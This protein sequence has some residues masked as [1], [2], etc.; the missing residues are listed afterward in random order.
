MTITVITLY[1][2]CIETFHPLS[3]FFSTQYTGIAHY[4]CLNKAF[5]V[6]IL[7]PVNRTE[8]QEAVITVAATEQKKEFAR[9]SCLGCS[10]SAVFCFPLYCCVCHVNSFQS[11]DCLFFVCFLFIYLLKIDRGFVTDEICVE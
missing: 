4:C 9:I 2:R 6:L 10:A 11:V 1:R 8:A 7:C 3:F 5:S